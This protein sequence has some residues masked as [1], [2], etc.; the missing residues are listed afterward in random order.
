[1]ANDQRI[2]LTCFSEYATIQNSCQTGMARVSRRYTQDDFYTHQFYAFLQ[3]KYESRLLPTFPGRK[4][5]PEYLN[6]R[7]FSLLII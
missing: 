1:M 6:M 4:K 2:S 5:I 3:L 7:G